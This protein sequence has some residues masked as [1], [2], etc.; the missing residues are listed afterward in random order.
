MLGSNGAAGGLG[1]GESI[2]RKIRDLEADGSQLGFVNSHTGKEFDASI[3][4]SRKVVVRRDHRVV[5]PQNRQ[6]NVQR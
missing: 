3:G 4:C 1:L 5:R 2:V 6:L